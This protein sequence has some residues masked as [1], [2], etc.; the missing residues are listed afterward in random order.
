MSGFVTKVDIS[1]N[2]QAK[3]Y[4]RK[5][6]KWSG[7][8]EFGTTFSAMTSG[9]DT[10]NL[11]S[12]QLSTTYSTF[13]GNNTTTNFTFG[14]SNMYLAESEISAITPSNSA[15]T[16]NI[17][18]IY[19]ATSSTTIDGNH[20]DLEFTG[21][22]YNIVVTSM[23][24]IALNT[25]TGQCAS[26]TLTYYTAGTLDFTGRTIWNDVHGITRTERLIVTDSPHIGYVLTCLDN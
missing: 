5:F 11:S 21:I 16:Q 7:G 15:I 19:T 4:V 10:N 8:T 14:D 3:Q 22:S 6:T 1:N 17:G 18:P 26:T 9:P 24:E 12:I 25:Y 2:R 23:E 20:V 13:S